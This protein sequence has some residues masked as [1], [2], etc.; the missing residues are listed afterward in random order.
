MIDKETLWAGSPVPVNDHN[1]C[2]CEDC[3]IILWLKAEKEVVALNKI[4]AGQKQK[5]VILIQFPQ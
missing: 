3:I 2:K 1:N 4:L 5:W